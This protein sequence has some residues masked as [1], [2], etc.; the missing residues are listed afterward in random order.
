MP[1]TI[2]YDIFAASMLEAAETA[3][4]ISYEQSVELPDDVL[5]DEIREQIVGKIISI[6]EK[7]EQVFEATILFPEANAGAEVTQFLNV[8]F[9]NVSLF[10]GVLVTSLDWNVWKN[11]N[12]GGPAF[13]IEGIRKQ[14]GIDGIRALTCTALKP[15]GSTPEKLAGFCLDFACGGIDIIKDDH[16]LA[17]QPYATFTDRLTACMDAIHKAADKTGKKAAYYPN[18]TADG[19]ETVRRY[20]AAW[21]AGAGGVLL[22]PHLCGIQTMH[23]LARTDI[24]LPIMAHPAFSGALV[25]N[26]RHGFTKRFLYG[27]LWRALG[28]DFSIYPNKGGR[29]S[30]SIEDCMAINDSCRDY[31]LPF[32]RTFPVPGG[33]L[34]RDSIRD[35]LDVYGNDTVFLIGGSLYQ[36]PKGIEYASREISGLVMEG[37][38]K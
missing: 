20:E 11:R 19:R 30:F 29:F 1:L 22:S 17:S 35:W 32:K 4:R 38:E 6:E 18:I 7:G 15:L 37:H 5:S 25:Q 21:K 28:A 33:G 23:E 13:G 36:H 8:L 9:G 34:Q 3:R 26:P 14:L 24:P 31:R 12:L 16:G 27:E 10:D 2:R